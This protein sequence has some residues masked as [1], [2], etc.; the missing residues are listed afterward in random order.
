MRPDEVTQ[1][2]VEAAEDAEEAALDELLDAVHWGRDDLPQKVREAY[3]HWAASMEHV[4]ELSNR[5]Y[6]RGGDR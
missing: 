1:A 5:L 2:A 3:A 6:A 4:T